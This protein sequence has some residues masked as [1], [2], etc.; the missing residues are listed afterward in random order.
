MR[1][2][3]STPQPVQKRPLRFLAH[4]R[5][6]VAIGA[7]DHVLRERPRH[8]GRAA[9]TAAALAWLRDHRD[10]V[11]RRGQPGEAAERHDETASI[12]FCHMATQWCA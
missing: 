12:Q 2:S 6:N 1:T 5:R 3:E 8:V 4:R 9:G 11:R 10:R 7:G